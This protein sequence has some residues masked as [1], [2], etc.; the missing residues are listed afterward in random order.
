MKK[1]RSLIF[2]VPALLAAR[3]LTFAAQE[4]PRNRVEVSLFAGYGKSMAEVGSAY[5]NEWST[6]GGERIAEDDNMALAPAP[7]LYAG[8]FCSFFIGRNIGIQAGF[9]YLRSPLSGQT[10]FEMRALVGPYAGRGNS[11]KG[12]GEITAVP[13]CLNVVGRVGTSG[14]QA[15]ASGGIAYFLNSFLADSS[16][17]AGTFIKLDFGTEMVTAF[18]VPVTV[19]D[20]TWSSFGADIGGGFDV[21]IGETLALTAEARFFYCPARTLRWTWTDGVVD[22]LGQN[23]F[24]RESAQLAGQR[25]TALHIH[26]SFFQISAG[27]KFFLPGVIRVSGGGR[28]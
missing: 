17:G 21:K 9:G 6:P 4:T 24:S 15:F 16:A 25:T 14:F 26:P 10:Q 5:H 12:K 1:K 13:L 27:L 28:R 8:G 23:I 19:A 3:A 11:W 22:D 20:T 18:K 2:L 7:A